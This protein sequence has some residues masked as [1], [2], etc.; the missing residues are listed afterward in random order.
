MRKLFFLAL[1]FFMTVAVTAQ[2][3]IELFMSATPPAT[4]SEWG[5][6]REVLML[7][8]SGQPGVPPQ[9]FLIKLQAEKTLALQ[10]QYSK[11]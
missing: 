7:M 5:N 8:I 4:L 11:L 10:D 1:T 3:K 9:K 6:R 2:L